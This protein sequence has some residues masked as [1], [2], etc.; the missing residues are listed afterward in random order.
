MYSISH[1]RGLQQYGTHKSANDA[2]FAI[3]ISLLGLDVMNETKAAYEIVPRVGQTSSSRARISNQ[4]ISNT[5]SHSNQNE[6]EFYFI[7]VDLLGILIKEHQ[8]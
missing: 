5:K 8:I 7:F 6:V 1:P 3:E 2:D 4:I